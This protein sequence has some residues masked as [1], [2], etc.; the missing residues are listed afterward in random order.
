IQN[1]H[2]TSRSVSK[3]T[4][5]IDTHRHVSRGQD[6][7]SPVGSFLRTFAAIGGRADHLAHAQT[8]ASD[9]A[10]HNLRPVVTTSAPIDA[11][12][13]A[14]LTPAQGDDIFTQTAIMQILGHVRKA[15][16]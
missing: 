12:G 6:V 16:L 1:V 13:T 15:A 3:R 5:G 8:T 14:E 9:E 11:R 2:R 10:R 7:S 4:G